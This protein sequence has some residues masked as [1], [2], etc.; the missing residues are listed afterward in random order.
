METDSIGSSALRSNYVQSCKHIQQ[1]EKAMEKVII[2]DAS[3]T[4]TFSALMR[5][6]ADPTHSGQTV[7]VIVP[8][9]GERK[10]IQADEEFVNGVTLAWQGDDGAS[11]NQFQQVTT[12]GSAWDN[13]LNTNSVLTINGVQFIDATGSNTGV[14]SAGQ[15]EK[16]IVNQSGHALHVYLVARAGDDPAHSGP[17]VGPHYI[18]NGGSALISYPG[19][20]LNALAFNWFDAGSHGSQTTTV[21]TR[22]SAWDSTLNM[23]DTITIHSV[24]GPELSGS[25]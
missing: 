12:R 8:P 18:D 25:N 5:R 2:N 22:G 23:N 10:Q 24:T 6:G 17:T 19:P 1:G 3:D 15:G 9:N 16:L 7:S 20:Y 13:L 14:S 11:G 4:V 21:T